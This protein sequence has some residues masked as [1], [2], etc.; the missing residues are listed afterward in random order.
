MNVLVADDEKLARQRLVRLLGEID[1]VTIVAECTNA[2][3]VLAAVKEQDVDV[4]LLDVE[5]PGLTGME[6]FAMMGPRAPFVVFCTAHASYAVEAFDRGAADYVLKPVDPKR[7]RVAI[8]RARARMDKGAP[9]RLA[10]ATQS[11]VILVDPRVVTHATLAQTSEGALVT[12][13]T[14]TGERHLSGDSLN[15]LE[16]KLPHMLRVHRRALVALDHVTKLEPQPTGGYVARIGTHA[17]EVS[18]QAARDLRK[19]LGLREG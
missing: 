17:V 9:Q 2:E 1:G 16:K 14:T 11:G 15:E 12:I 6:A 10:I 5:M 3:E 18:R 19:K 4:A 8:E 13:F 7:L